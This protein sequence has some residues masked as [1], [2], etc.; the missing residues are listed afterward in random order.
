MQLSSKF[1]CA[2]VLFFSLLPIISKAQSLGKIKGKVL[3]AANDNPMAYATVSLLS[4]PDSSLITGT[5]CDI[6][7][8][9][10]LNNIK[11]GSYW[12]RLS[13]VSYAD[14]YSKAIQIND[15]NKTVDIGTIKM[16]T[17]A[18]E[19]GTVEVSAEKS[20][21]QLSLDKRVYNVDK[22]LSNAG[23]SAA[24]ILDNVPSVEVDIDGNVSLRGSGNVR[25][26]IDGKPSGLI[27]TGSNS[28]LRQIQANMIE[29]VEIITNPSAKFDAS[30]QAGIINIILKKE[31]REGLNGAFDINA[32]YPGTLGAAINLNYRKKWFNLFANYAIGYRRNPGKGTG[33]QAF[34]LEDT[35][36][37]TS[38]T[39]THDRGG[40]SNTIRLG[41]DIYPGKKQTITGSFL[42]K[43]S[44]ENNYS[45]II[46][47]DFNAQKEPL[48]STK[49]YDHEVELDNDLEWSLSYKKEFSSDKHILTADV[50]YVKS[51]ETEDSDIEESILNTSINPLLQSSYNAEY[52]RTILAQIDYIKPF[53]KKGVWEL[54]YRNNLRNIDNAFEVKEQNENGE[55][56]R[57]VD[58]SNSLDYTENIYAAYTSFGN[59]KGN[60]GYKLGLRAEYSEIETFLKET[61]EKNPRDYLNL[62]PTAHFT[63]KLN[64]KN[65]IQASYS[66]RIRRPGFWHLNPFYSFTDNRNYYSGNPNLN[67]EY[68]NSFEGGYLKYFKNGSIY[69]GIYYR[70]TTGVFERISTV[71]KEGMTVTLPVNLS[72]RDDYG[73]EFNYNHQI[74]KGW[75]TNANVNLFYQ[76]VNGVYNDVSLAS[77]AL[78]ISGRINTRKTI[79]K[80]IDGQAAFRYRAPKNT[81]QGRNRSMYNLDL[82]FSQDFY[83]GNATWSLSVKDVFNT[84]KRRSI[85]EGDNFYSESE[86]Q[87]RSRQIVATITYR[88]NQK[89][90]KGARLSSS[91]DDF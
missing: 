26:L 49:R 67:P 53:S 46:Y 73:L 5:L 76:E 50:K 17:A 78:S 32:G 24:E 47:N 18:Q 79:W 89:K 41:T 63:Y 60:F 45:T 48:Y 58:Y 28:G 34:Y 15:Q 21:M 83:K 10:E 70:H 3:D 57:L 43:F 40:L 74:K 44:K 29:R 14:Y 59:E 25:I 66:R 16:Q 22:D 85:T 33:D 8:G 75:S 81:T 91:D 13:F 71:D 54:G 4:A 39:R 36:Y 12:I 65:Q 19:L 80:N 56:I 27:G 82:G 88:L 61:N 20:Q 2:I 87:W 77:E 9:F 23:G 1:Y 7:G 11:A 51:E 86:F 37:Y 69:S 52:E 72:T 35:T 68:T 84:R 55:F 64:G 31:K 30:G 6:E 62:F 38:R 90:S 42:Y